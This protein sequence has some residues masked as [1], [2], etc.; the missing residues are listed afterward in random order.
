M[1]KNKGLKK[2][3]LQQHLQ[4]EEQLYYLT[5]AFGPEALWTT[6]M[7]AAALVK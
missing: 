5:G 2:L 7:T 6:P 4:S 3:K 1:E